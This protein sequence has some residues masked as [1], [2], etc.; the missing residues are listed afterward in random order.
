MFYCIHDQALYVTSTAHQFFS[1]PR[2]MFGR[3]SDPNLMAAR[4]NRNQATGNLKTA[5]SSYITNVQK[6]NTTLR[7]S[8]NAYKLPQPYAEAINKAVAN[9]VFASRKSLSAT[10]NALKAKEEA[11]K[12]KAVANAAREAAKANAAAKASAARQQT[13]TNK[14]AAAAK[15]AAKAVANKAAAEKAAINALRANRITVKQLNSILSKFPQTVNSLEQAWKGAR[16]SPSESNENLLNKAR[17]NAN[18]NIKGR[19]FG[20]ARYRPLW[21]KLLGENAVP[22]NKKTALKT[23]QNAAMARIKEVFNTPYISGAYDASALSANITKASWRAPPYGKSESILAIK[24]Y[25]NGKTRNNIIRNMKNILAGA[26]AFR[27]GSDLD[28]F[29]RLALL[30]RKINNN[31]ARLMIPP[32]PI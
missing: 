4:K 11:A 20:N 9:L 1:V 29:F 12:A 2:V 7:N 10:A 24:R 15:A 8:R 23:A 14:A 31:Q 28:K 27:P 26:P 16:R 13:A 21:V 32:T 17:A 3:T 18:A 22:K 19:T 25:T 5:L 30:R 6:L